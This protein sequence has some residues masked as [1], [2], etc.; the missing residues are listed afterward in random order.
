MPPRRKRAQPAT[1]N[2]EAVPP[3]TPK[4]AT[5]KK[6]TPRKSSPKKSTPRKKKS[7]SILEV[8]HERLDRALRKVTEGF[9]TERTKKQY[10]SYLSQADRFL[11]LYAPQVCKA[12][13]LEGADALEVHDAFQRLTSRSVD[14]MIAFIT[15]K[16]VAGGGALKMTSA[17][18]EKDNEGKKAPKKSRKGKAQKSNPQQA[19]TPPANTPPATPPPAQAARKGPKPLSAEEVAATFFEE[20]SQESFRLGLLPTG[21]IPDELR[22]MPELPASDQPELRVQAEEMPPREDLPE[23]EETAA[24]TAAQSEVDAAHSQV[25]EALGGPSVAR[26]SQAAFRWRFVVLYNLVSGFWCA[27][28]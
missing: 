3:T 5:P 24:E 9:V 18:T 23:N 13:G 16:C 26:T 28:R 14:M 2:T 27:D 19:T 12:E 4:K 22:Q 11:E 17:S 25:E 10:L 20:R 7:L 21:N 1:P 15:A 6:A 8:D